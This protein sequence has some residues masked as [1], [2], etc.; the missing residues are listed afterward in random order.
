M[1][2]TALPTREDVFSLL[3]G[4]VDPELGCD[5]VELGMARDAVVATDGTVTVTIALTTAGCPLKA[6]IKRDVTA[7]LGSPTIDI[8]TTRSPSTS[9]AYTATAAHHTG[10]KSVPERRAMSPSCVL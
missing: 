2:T 1:A 6:Q 3:A 9:T 10:A 7:R 8:A 4:V 5:I